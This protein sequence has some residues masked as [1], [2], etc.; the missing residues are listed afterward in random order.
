MIIRPEDYITEEKTNSV[1]LSS[2]LSRESSGFSKEA[3]EN[4]YKILKKYFQD[5][6]VRFEELINTRDVWCR[7]FMPVQITK[8]LF[9]SFTYYPDYLIEQQFAITNWE[10]HNVHSRELDICRIPHRILPLILDGG[11]VIKAI[12]K[13][14]KPTCILC[15]KV[16]EEN[17]VSKVELENWWNRYFEGSLELVLLPWE[18]PDYNPIGHADGIVRYISK[19]KVLMTNYSE[20]D[21]ELAEKYHNILK[22]HGFEVQELWYRKMFSEED[23]LWKLLKN[24][25]WCYINF[26]Q[27][28][29]NILLP[30]LGYNKLD[31]LALEQIKEAFDNGFNVE[32]IDCDMTEIIGGD[33]CGSNSGG[34]LNCLTWNVSIEKQS[35]EK[36]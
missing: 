4:L 8:D 29:H 28:D 2:L 20:Y 22:T 34:A 1:F 7:D 35:D 21:K 16:L 14:G 36:A 13:E 3:R 27:V 26:L 23:K 15:D 5:K 30:R 32:M 19:G 9:L 10:L 6:G 18:G 24:H 31:N 33:G 11:N 25:S 12:N 17:K